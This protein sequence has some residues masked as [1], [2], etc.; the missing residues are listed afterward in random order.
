MIIFG[1]LAGKEVNGPTI[2]GPAP[3]IGLRLQRLISR[4]ATFLERRNCLQWN[5]LALL[6]LLG[7]CCIRPRSDRHFLV[8]PF[9]SH[10]MIKNP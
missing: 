4:T 9:N 5:M 3:E 6:A 1:I 2:F 8:T 10:S 7:R